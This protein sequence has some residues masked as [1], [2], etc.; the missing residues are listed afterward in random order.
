MR[1]FQKKT[2]H[3]VCFIRSERKK[4]CRSPKFF[5]GGTIFVGLYFFIKKQN[6]LVRVRGL[7]LLK[8]AWLAGR[9]STSTSAL[10]STTMPSASDQSRGVDALAAA[11]SQRVNTI[12][13]KKKAQ[14]AITLSSFHKS[15]L[16]ASK[17]AMEDSQETR[18]PSSLPSSWHAIEESQDTRLPSS[19]ENSDDESQFSSVGGTPREQ[20]DPQSSR[21]IVRYDPPLQI[22]LQQ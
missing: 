3:T 20:W 7:A 9:L 10:C 1:I 12:T 21:H 2:Y 14:L 18:L 17:R 4:S 22:H 15:S 16:P 11:Q 19:H 6:I 13:V 8:F 5:S